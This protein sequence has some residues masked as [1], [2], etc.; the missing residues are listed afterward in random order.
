MRIVFVA[1]WA[2]L[3]A[4]CS[5]ASATRTTEADGSYGIAVSC[6]LGSPWRCM[7][8][9]AEWCPHGYM[10]LNEPAPAGNH[11]SASPYL[12]QEGPHWTMRVRCTTSRAQQPHAVKPIDTSY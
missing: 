5:G 9:I 6:R 10:A 2:A 12:V 1:L 4:G 7:D 11:T 8:E 3:I